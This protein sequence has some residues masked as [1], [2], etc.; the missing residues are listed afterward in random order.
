MKKFI[1][2]LFTLLPCLIFAQEEKYVLLTIGTELTEANGTERL[3]LRHL[4]PQN[5]AGRQIVKRLQITPQPKRIFDKD[6]CRYAEFDIAPDTLY[7]KKIEIRAILEI[8]QNDLKTIKKSE[9]RLR[10]DSSDIHQ[11]LLAERY[12]EK[13][14]SVVIKLA[15]RLKGRDRIK[16]AENIYNYIR[17]N[18]QHSNYM[19]GIFG[20]R[21]AIESGKG[22]CTEFATAFVALCRAISIPARVVTGYTSIW[23]GTPK[24]EWAEF[25]DE[26]LG[27]IP[28]DP[29]KG[30][31]H[32]FDSL[33]NKYVYLSH[34]FHDSNLK[35]RFPYYYRYQ[36]KAPK[37]KEISTIKT[38][39]LDW[40]FD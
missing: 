32:K 18:I 25:Y 9:T 8:R 29:T 37:L 1:F 33:V 17:S 11:Y 3:L 16:S 24:Y 13:D 26:S 12:I 34:L 5:I 30:S 27:W 20:A 7:D 2:V 31:G 39:R 21:Y 10:A 22:D 4:V 19:P 6:G 35:N 23:A 14:D 38:V 15:T 28:V 40:N 36:G